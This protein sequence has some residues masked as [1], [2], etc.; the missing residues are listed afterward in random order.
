[1]KVLDIKAALEWVYHDQKVEATYP[2]HS[3]QGLCVKLSG[4]RTFAGL[5]ET[6]SDLGIVVRGG[7]IP[8]VAV[9]E[10]AEYIHSVVCLLDKPIAM[11]L[12]SYAKR[13]DEPWWA[14]E[15]Y[16][17]NIPLLRKGK[18]VM[19]YDANN[20]PVGPRMTTVGYPSI[21]VDAA[22]AEYTLWFEA[23]L[24]VQ[25]YLFKQGRPLVSL[26][27][28]PIEVDEKPWVR[29]KVLACTN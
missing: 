6:A 12:M 1:M 27:L 4:M 25:Q 21:D 7:R 9:D 16:E 11:L 22:R 3:G 24:A 20:N 13:Q 19:M 15:G 28:K 2:K 17:R 10:D 5:T 18:P 8:E 23:L 14:P 29:K 26:T